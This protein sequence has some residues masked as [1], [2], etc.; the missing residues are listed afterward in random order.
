MGEKRRHENSPNV[1]SAKLKKTMSG[2]DSSLQANG[3]ESIALD[4]V[5]MLG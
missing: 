4:K 3:I 5:V 2:P 1:K